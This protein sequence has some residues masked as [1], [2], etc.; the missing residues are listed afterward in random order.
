MTQTKGPSF[1]VIA[2]NVGTVY[3]GNNY[4]QAIRKYQAYVKL[5]KADTGRVSGESVVL[6]NDGEPIHEHGEKEI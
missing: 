5:S 1:E 3:S 6:F 4:M 2:G